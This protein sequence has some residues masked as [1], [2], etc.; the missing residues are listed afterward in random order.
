MLAIGIVVDDAIVVV[1]NVER[2][3]EHGLPPREAAR[4]A[5]DEVTG[6]VIAVALVLCAVFVPCAFISGITGQFFRQFAITIAVS[7]VI[8]AFNSLTLSPALAAI[9]LK[10]HGHK[11]DILTRLLDAGLGWFFKLFNMGFTVST[12]VYTR[13]VGLLLRTSVIALL[14][15]GGL[16]YLTYWSFARAPTG[17][18]P[19]QDKGYLL[20]NVQLPDSA[21]VQRTQ[22]VMTHI[23]RLV[24]GDKAEAAR[25]PGIAGVQH[26]VSI[27]GQSL[28]LGAN[29]PN[30][31]SMNVMLRPFEQRRGEN[32]TGDAIAGQIRALCR[33][34][35]R[36]AVVT[37]FAA[38]PIDGLGTAGGFK[39]MIEDRGP[40]GLAAL[41]HVTDDVVANAN[42]TR[43]LQGAFT[44]FRNETP[45]LYLDID[46]D[47]CMAMGVS[48]G[49]VFNSLQVY[50]GSYYVNN[51]NKFGRSWQVNIMAD[52]SY[53]NRIEEI[54]LLKVKNSKGQMVPLSA[55]AAIEDRTGPVLLMRYNM[56]SAAAVY[57][58]SSPGVSSDQALKLMEGACDKALPKMMARE[59]TEL[60]YMQQQAGNTAM[61]VFLLAVVFVFLVLAAQYESWSLPLAVILVVPMCLLCSVVGRGHGGDGRQHFHADRL[62]GAGGPGEQERDPDRGVR[63]AAA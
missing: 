5:M 33:K 62:R 48:L 39:I 20:V 32:L 42:Q 40:M 28:L 59:W 51:F 12:T 38:P 19:T 53:R 37:V 2:W 27:S 16:L 1:E 4:K 23:D 45:W 55:M 63:Q 18:I 30:F 29:A 31:G 56:Y 54:K 25:F 10:P 50:L 14:V 15:Y 58:N 47:K 17:F 36:D 13:L 7:T 44:S 8:S 11:R 46:R 9:L 34:H 3:L 52:A 41:Q 49:D 26:T 22:A 35:I 60:A 57:G 24:R 61:W 43:G 6:P 21:S